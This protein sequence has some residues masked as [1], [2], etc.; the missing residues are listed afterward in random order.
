MS[1]ATIFFLNKYM[2]T[3]FLFHFYIYEGDRECTDLQLIG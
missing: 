3:V 1:F 2:P